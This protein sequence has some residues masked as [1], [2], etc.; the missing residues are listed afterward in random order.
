MAALVMMS[1]FPAYDGKV[2]RR[3][4]DLE[5]D[6][7][8]PAGELPVHVGDTYGAAVVEPFELHLSV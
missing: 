3:S 6:R 8:L 5:E 2:V 1:R 7:D 4:L